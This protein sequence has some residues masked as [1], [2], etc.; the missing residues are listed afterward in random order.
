MNARA[1]LAELLK[2][3]PGPDHHPAPAGG[4]G[5]PDAAATHDDAPGGE[6]R[7]L[8]VLHQITELSLRIVQHADAGADHL[9]QVVGRDIGGHA[10]GDAGGAVDQ[11]IG[12]AAGQHTGFLA[13]L[14]KVGVPV[15]GVLLNVPQHLVG[16]LGQ[17]GLGVTVGG[18][19]I[20]IYGA[21]VAVAVHQHIPHGEVLGQTDQGVID[22]LVA[23]GVVAAQHVTYA[24]SRLFEG[25]I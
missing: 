21:E 20:A 8:D 25:L 2:L 7:P 17:P 13:A 15:H 23:V 4:I 3:M 24:G 10:H 19:G 6:V 11:Q 12:E 1:V 14:V 22:G 5:L 9:P 16:E 18:G